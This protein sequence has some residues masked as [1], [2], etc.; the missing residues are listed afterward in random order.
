MLV[1]RDNKIHFAATTNFL[2]ANHDA[3]SSLFPVSTEI[4]SHGGIVR[5]DLYLAAH[6]SPI[7]RNDRC[8][9]GL[10]SLSH[11]YLWYNALLQ[12]HSTMGIL[13][14]GPETRNARR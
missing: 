5:L 4:H 7:N 8:G 2:D 6:P 14:A 3:R 12:A 11:D 1:I 10:H 13:F 9:N